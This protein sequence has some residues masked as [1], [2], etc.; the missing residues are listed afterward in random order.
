[1]CVRKIVFVISVEIL[2]FYCVHP[3]RLESI[4]FANGKFKLLI[5]YIQISRELNNKPGLVLD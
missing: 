5:S 1:M 2:I 3:M 4:K